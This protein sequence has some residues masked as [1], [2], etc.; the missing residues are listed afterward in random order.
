MKDE[1][2]AL[3]IDSSRPLLISDADEVLFSF[4]Q[5]FERF[6]NG[7]GLSFSWA[8]FRLNGNIIDDC[9][10]EAVE[11]SA[12]RS[13]IYA[14]FEN[15]TRSIAAVEGAAECLRRLDRHLQIVVLSNIW[16]EFRDARAHALESQGMPY[17]VIANRGSKAPA[18]AD[19]ASRTRRPVFFVDDIPQH[20]QDVANVACDVIRIHYVANRRLAGLLGS[21]TSC[22]HQAHDWPGI[23][24]YIEN[25]LGVSPS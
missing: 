21:T 25:C 8:S 24:S 16:P 7:R 17:P 2:D 10:G 6:L 13:L 14:F 12:V 9:T 19:L 23:C 15:H 1:L 5:D 3:G 11:A 22:H 4:M 20:H 18:V